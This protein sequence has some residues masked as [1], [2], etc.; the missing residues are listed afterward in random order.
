MAA[1]AFSAAMQAL[2]LAEEPVVRA[3]GAMLKE[4]VARAGDLP[5]AHHVVSAQLLDL[6]RL[7]LAAHGGGMNR[8]Y[9]KHVTLPLHQLMVTLPGP[10]GAAAEHCLTEDGFPSALAMPADKASFLHALRR[11]RG[12]RAGSVFG[13]APSLLT[14]GFCPFAGGLTGLRA[15]SDKFAAICWGLAGKQ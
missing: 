6:M 4:V 2:P 12:S 9:L 11:E 10:A 14:L 8:T 1:A 3:A 5:G 15:H 13:R 7:L